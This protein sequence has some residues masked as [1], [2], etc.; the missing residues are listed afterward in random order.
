MTRSWK[1]NAKTTSKKNIYRYSSDKIKAPF[2]ADKFFY[3][4]HEYSIF[5]IPND[6]YFDFFFICLHATSRIV[7]FILCLVWDNSKYHLIFH[8]DDLALQQI[9]QVHSTKQDEIR[10]LIS[11]KRIYCILL[12]QII[13]FIHYVHNSTSTIRSNRLHIFQRKSQ[14]TQFFNT[15]IDDVFATLIKSPLKHKLMTLQAPPTIII[16][17]SKSLY[18]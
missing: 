10:Y 17:R 2:F 13:T 6:P 3:R 8:V 5:N 11:D 4:F 16:Y 1:Y 9:S 7:G 14:S 15:F 12:T 18:Q